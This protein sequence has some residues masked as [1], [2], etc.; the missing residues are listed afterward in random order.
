MVFEASKKV[1]M[2]TPYA[3]L[4]ISMGVITFVLAILLPNLELVGKIIP[5][6][7]ISFTQKISILFGLL[8]SITTNFTVLSASYTILIAILFGANIALITFYLK[9]RIT[10]VRQSGM[11][12]GVLGMASGVLGLGCAACG[13]IIIS[14]ILPIFGGGALLSLLPL[15]G[16]EFGILGVILLSI[17]YYLTVKQIQNPATCKIS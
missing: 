9:N 12:T 14:A 11:A 15:H 17:S 4:A 1:F 6:A 10:E 13:S 3:I 16:S 8:G 5:D 7:T 2:K